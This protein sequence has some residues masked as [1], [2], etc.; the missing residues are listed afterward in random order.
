MKKLSAKY[1]LK[2]IDYFRRDDI[3]I[4]AI[5]EKDGFY[6]S[7]YDKTFIQFEEDFRN[8]ELIDYN[9]KFIINKLENFQNV[10][11]DIIPICEY[12]VLKVL[13]TYYIMVENGTNGACIEEIENKT[14][15]KLL[16]RLQEL[17][18][19]KEK[20]GIKQINIE[21]KSGR[22]VFRYNNRSLS[23]N[24]KNFWSFQ[25]SN[26]ISSKIRDNISK[27]IVAKALNITDRKF[28][29][30]DGHDLTSK[31]GIPIDVRS[32]S[33]ITSLGEEPFK[34]IEFKI[35]KNGDIKKLYGFIYVFC[36]LS[37][38]T[39]EGLDPLDINQWEFYITTRS[40]LEKILNGDE[41][42]TLKKLILNDAIESEYENL[43]KDVINLCLK[44][45]RNNKR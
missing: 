39:K 23:Y 28:E 27:F 34:E 19:E 9:F 44:E 16:L 21:K 32:A 37:H 43:Y 5:E 26:L 31:E 10:L 38:R 6:Y 20:E 15:L 12:S 41:K 24:L 40:N 18:E 22:E 36:L 30:F 29:Y 3:R 25:Y 2:Y 42:I 7:T 35:Y 4:Y 11:Y 13:F 45:I 8:S 17:L 1:M 14:F 33:Y